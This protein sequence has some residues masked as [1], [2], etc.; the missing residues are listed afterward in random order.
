M[1]VFGGVI[2]GACLLIL[3]VPASGQDASQPFGCPKPGTVIKNSLN[4]T[5]TFQPT[6]E[7]LVCVYKTSQQGAD[8]K[9]F[10]Q[11]TPVGSDTYAAHK[12]ELAA[13]WPL[14]VG[15]AA[16]F[17]SGNFHYHYEVKGRET[18]TT[19]AGEFQAIKVVMSQNGISKDNYQAERQFWFAPSV[20]YLVKYEYRA[21]LGKPVATDLSWEAVQVTPK[22]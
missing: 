16:D 10:A 2:A 6:S 13:L 12:S 8:I 22:R 17:T 18:V 15:K 20:G 11:L 5:Y 7:D 21:I 19:K 4:T 14:Q 9:R 3:A 1:R